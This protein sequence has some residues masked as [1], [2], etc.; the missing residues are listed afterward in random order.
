MGEVTISISD[1]RGVA[2]HALL[3]VHLFTHLHLQYKD[4]TKNRNTNLRILRKEKEGSSP[5]CTGIY[6]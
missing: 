2:Q 5:N 6:E 1:T 4:P 3:L